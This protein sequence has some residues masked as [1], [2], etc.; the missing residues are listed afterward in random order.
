MFLLLH[1]QYRSVSISLTVYTMYFVNKVSVLSISVPERYW[2]TLKLMSLY[3]INQG[4]IYS[5]NWTLLLA[6]DRNEDSEIA[7]HHYL[8]ENLGSEHIHS[9][10]TFHAYSTKLKGKYIFENNEFISDIN[11]NSQIMVYGPCQN[12]SPHPINPLKLGIQRNYGGWI[13]LHGLNYS[14]PLR[15]PSHLNH[16]SCSELPQSRMHGMS[17]IFH[18]RLHNVTNL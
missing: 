18:H 15:L 6:D 2:I 9:S 16:N 13:A 17:N 11:S 8:F 14:L 10:A 4:T 1:S 12:Q 5:A 7:S 3:W